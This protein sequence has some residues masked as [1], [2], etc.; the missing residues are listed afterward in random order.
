MVKSMGLHF[1]KQM[2]ILTDWLIP[3]P[4]EILTDW[5]IPKHWVKQTE[6]R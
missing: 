1:Q 5:L 3:K 2:V 4:M 6:M